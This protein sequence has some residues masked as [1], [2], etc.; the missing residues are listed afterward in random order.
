M[1]R[2]AWATN[3]LLIRYHDSEWGIPLHDDQRLFEF[4][5]LEGM[6]A[7]LS[8]HTIL[9][10][11]D[12]FRF[13]FDNFH[14]RK[15]STYDPPKI[16]QLLNNVDIIRNRLKIM[17]AIHNAKAFLEIQK[18]YGSF[19]CYIWQFV[20]GNPLL[21]MWREHQHV[22]C[23]TQESDAMS[24][25]LKQYG[26]TFVGPTICYAFMQATGMVNDHTIDCFRY[27][28]KPTK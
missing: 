1:T 12:A 21:N 2:C 13:A 22:P 4:L 19:D 24:K 11:R 10:K 20:G 26:F 7:G 23:R 15:I 16:E 8:W 14:A 9:Q 25:N 27:A 18:Q 6:Q 28:C 5:I 17:A 3:E